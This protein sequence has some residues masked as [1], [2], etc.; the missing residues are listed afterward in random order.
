MC[1][2]MAQTDTLQMTRE[3]ISV[4]LGVWRDGMTQAAVKLQSDGLIEDKRGRLRVTDAEGLKA[5]SCECY[6]VVK[7][8]Y[9]RLL[10]N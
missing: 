9:G 5:T 6:R 7:K 10:S 4:M 8:E 1:R 2:D 3:L